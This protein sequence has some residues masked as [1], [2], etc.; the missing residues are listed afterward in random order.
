VKDTADGRADNTVVMEKLREV[1]Y[2]YSLAFTYD[3]HLSFPQALEKGDAVCV[4]P[5]GA[6]R[7]HPTIA[8]LKTG[9][10]LSSSMRNVVS[11]VTLFTVARLASDVLTDKKDD[12]NFEISILTASITYM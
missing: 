12:P 1:S 5:E 6:S 2:S 8:P 9:G 11:Y 4:F 10:P 7:Y 3:A